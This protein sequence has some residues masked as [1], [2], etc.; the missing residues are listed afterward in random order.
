[1]YR[2][3]PKNNQPRQISQLFLDKEQNSKNCNLFPAATAV[4]S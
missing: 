2:T 4:N 1:M 3:E